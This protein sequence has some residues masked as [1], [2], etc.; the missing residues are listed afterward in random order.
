MGM[1]D[2]MIADPYASG[3]MID[4]KPA[5]SGRWSGRKSRHDQADA[6]SYRPVVAD[7]TATRTGV[8]ASAWVHAERAP[9]RKPLAIMT[10]SLALG[11]DAHHHCPAGY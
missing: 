2:A 1:Q 9:F 5:P 8:L 6:G 4:A 10:A 11:Y 3:V 7:W